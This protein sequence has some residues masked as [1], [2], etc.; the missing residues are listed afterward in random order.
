MTT[1]AHHM[2]YIAD[3]TVYKAVMFARKLMRNGM[4][5][6]LANYKA[7]R[8]Y[9]VNTSQVARYT[10]QVGARIAQRYSRSRK[11]GAK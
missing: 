1:N 9:F 2:D 7:A 5:P 4:K 3:K 10:G 8:F 11:G 6:G